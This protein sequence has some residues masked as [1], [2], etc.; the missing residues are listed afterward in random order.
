MN[1]LE[2]AL[3]RAERD[4][5]LPESFAAPNAGAL[6]HFP[7]AEKGG[8]ADATNVAFR[9]EA[10]S[11]AVALP[12]PRIEPPIQ[13]PIP[14]APEE[15]RAL[16]PNRAG[17][18]FTGKL[19][20]N[21]IKPAAVEQYRRLAAALHHAQ[22][23]NGIKVVMVASALA[24][25]GKTLTAVNLALTLSESY[26]RRVLLMD[27]DFR[28]PTLHDVFKVPNV[29]G[30]NDALQADADRKLT[31]IEISPR[32]SLLPAGRPNPDPMSGL[33]SDRMREII[34]EAAAKFDWVILDTPPVGLLTDAHLL[35]AM[36]NVAV[37]VVQAGRTPCSLVQRAIENVDRNRVIGVVLNCVE[38]R[39]MS[40][41]GRYEQYYAADYATRDDGLTNPG[42]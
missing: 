21:E 41:E 40:P 8:P 32:L 10:A 18:S 38:D 16:E 42:S 23:N 3:R 22:S 12:T 24:G 7:V 37:L 25:E 31:V 29:T 27:A 2:E 13:A 1:R 39:A 28:R 30:L 36:V 6:E 35:A 14:A 4:P 17:K 15:P 33:T 9:P 20:I 5:H 34:D 19:V 11:V 26:G